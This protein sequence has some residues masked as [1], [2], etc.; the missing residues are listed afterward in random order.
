MARAAMQMKVSVRPIEEADA[1]WLV[2]WENWNDA[3]YFVCQPGNALLNTQYNRE[4]DA[5]HPQALEQEMVVI[6]RSG[7]PVGLVKLTPDLMPGTA[8]AYVYLHDADAYA[9][10]AVRKSFRLMLGEMSKQQ[11][12]QRLIL[13][14]A[15]REPALQGFATA[16]GFQKAGVEREALFLHGTR[17]D[18]GVFILDAA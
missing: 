9:S 3:S 18:V 4:M 10:E 12:F 15:E 16:L 11:E 5:L 6:E 17:H 14:A 2:G 7:A 1:E 8:R 13:R